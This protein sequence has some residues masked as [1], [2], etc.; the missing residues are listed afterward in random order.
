MT[1]ENRKLLFVDDEPN[2]LEAFIRMLRPER[3]EWDIRTANSADEALQLVA[4]EPVD[5][6]VSDYSMPGRNGFYLLQT[7]RTI[8]PDLPFI[9]VTGN[10]D[11]GLKRNA[12]ELGATDL[13]NKPVDRDDLVA[14]LRNV[15]RLKQ[16]QDALKFHT[17][18]LEE[19]V[20]ERTAELE[21]SRHEI[22]WRLAKA[23]EL[24]DEDTG[25]HVIRVGC[26]CRIIAEHLGLSKDFVRLI[27]L[28]SPLH[29][30]GKIGVPDTILLK[31]GPLTD[32]EWSVMRSHCRHGAEILRQDTKLMQAIKDWAPAGTMDS[33]HRF[34]HPILEMASRIALSHHEKWAGNGYPHGLSGEDIPLEARIVAVADVFDALGSP[35]P[36]KPALPDEKVME[37][38][39]EGRGTH[40][41]PKVYDAFMRALP[42]IK[43]VREHFAD[44]TVNENLAA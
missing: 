37:I 5:A 24:R 32:E 10:Q 22:I 39:A 33:N 7:I 28:S 2:V 20:Q 14:R 13:L 18:H 40:F 3:K 31:R 42:E 17:T 12:L 36:Y 4:A 6:I 25:N 15:L 16:Y 21:A 35:R 29:D 27:F 1:T 9:I 23:G 34:T 26:Y 38:M 44:L 8:E 19:L 11:A 41:D 43:Q 30:I